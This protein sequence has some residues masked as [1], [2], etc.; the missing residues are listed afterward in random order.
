MSGVAVTVLLPVY[1]GETYVGKAIE[2]VLTQSFRDFELLALDDGSHD[3]TPE[4]LARYAAID[5]RVRVLR[6]D[7]RGVGYT[8]NRGLREARGRYI[9]ELGSDDLALPDRLE[10][11]V[12][13]F[14][15]HDDYVAAG[16][17]LLIIDCNDRGIGLRSYPTSDERLRACMLLY[18]PFGSPAM[19]Y[20]RDDA[21]AAG[22]YT[23]RFSTCE[24]YDFMLRL[25][26]R[27][28]VANLPEPLTA[29]RFHGA[30][31]KSTKTLAQ[32]RDTV[33]IKRVAFAEYGYRA[34]L[35]ARAVNLAQDV[36]ARLPAGL[37][38]WLFDKIFIRAE[39]AS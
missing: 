17:Y 19:M 5:P 33:A 24:D 8:L 12:T 9:A 2:S 13:F 30:S 37:S 38:Y 32:L 1:N 6:H 39:C 15:A 34:T 11:Q 29:Y 18:N 4:I 25:A 27:G 31:T 3:R 10:K 23:D 20:R 26:K 35:V 21:L 28:K 36:L 22:G 7:N 14:D 16:G